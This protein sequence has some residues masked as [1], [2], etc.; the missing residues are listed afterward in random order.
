[1]LNC[2]NLLNRF[3]V[4]WYFVCGGN[5]KNNY[6]VLKLHFCFLYAYFVLNMIMLYSCQ[7]AKLSISGFTTIFECVRFASILYSLC[8]L[9]SVFACL[10]SK[11]PIR[12]AYDVRFSQLQVSVAVSWSG[13]QP[14]L[15]QN[16]QTAAGVTS[17]VAA[18]DWQD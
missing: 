15:L 4:S 2:F 18:G 8:L 5:K 1:M 16:T 7:I 6:S 11:S 12:D 3:N 13:G 17:A 9:F 10:L 14:P